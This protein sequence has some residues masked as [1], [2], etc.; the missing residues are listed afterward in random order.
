[1]RS[2]VLTENI[3]N[4]KNPILMAVKSFINHS[5]KYVINSTSKILWERKKKPPK[6]RNLDTLSQYKGCF[7]SS[8]YLHVCLYSCMCHAYTHANEILV[9]IPCT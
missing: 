8:T 2:P 6:S 9:K 4:I 7:I 5:D 1:M 3:L